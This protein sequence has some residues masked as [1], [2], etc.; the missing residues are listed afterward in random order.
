MGTYTP[1]QR[2]YKADPTEFVNV[3]SQVNYN[4]RRA[5][6]RVRSIVEWQYADTLA[7]ADDFPKDI[8][9]KFYNNATNTLFVVRDSSLV[10]SQHSANGDTDPWSTVGITYLN[11]WADADPDTLRLSYRK[12]P[13]DGVVTWRGSMQS[14]NFE[15]IAP[16]SNIDAISL[17]ASIRP[18]RSKYFTIHMGPDSSGYSIARILFNST[19]T[20]QIN[21][22]GVNNQTNSADRYYSFHDISYPTN[23]T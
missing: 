5:D 23:D 7:V 4:I 17:D 13:S 14:N 8:G 16:N 20:V 2:F 15:N 9:Y 18:A 1:T 6:E 21:R 3:E 11:L 10:L 12:E 19:G 22:M